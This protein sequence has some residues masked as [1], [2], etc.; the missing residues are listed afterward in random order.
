M[1]LVNPQIAM[2]YRPTVEY[3]PR[4]AL[5]D[6]AQVMSLQQAQMQM[7][8]LRQTDE[9]IERIRQ[10]SMK[11]GGPSDTM[12][13]AKAFLS[14]PVAEHQT[15][16]FKIFQQQRDKA[17]FD[18]VLGR[19]Y[20][21]LLTS[22]QTSPAAAAATTAAAPAAASEGDLVAAPMP[23]PKGVM[24][25]VAPGGAVGPETPL[26]YLKRQF[27]TP[28][29]PAT[30][31]GTNALPAA[32]GATAPAA[33]PVVNAMAAPGAAPAAG[34]TAEQ[35]RQEII[36][37]SGL[38]DP[39]AKALAEVLKGQLSEL[40]KTHT[41]GG[42]IVTGGGR[43]IYTAP[44][45]IGAIEAEIADLR[46]KGV[47]DNDPRIVA[48]LGKIGQLSGAGAP[49]DITR[50]MAE[51]DRLIAS[52]R[53]AADPDVR[54]LN[55]YIRK[56]TTHA[57]G[58][59]VTVTQEK[60]EAGEFGKLL[61][62]GYEDVLKAA[63]LA[64]TT[65]PSLD[66]QTRILDQGFTTGFGT[67]AKTAGASVLAALG[68][69]NAEKFATNS[70]TFLAATQQAVLQK[71]LEQKGT[72]TAADAER[73]TQT[74]AQRG[75]TVDANRFLIDVAREQLQRDIERKDFFL[76]WKE[77][78][79]SFSGAETAWS[80]TEGNKSLFDRPALKKYLTPSAAEVD[81]RTQRLEN[82]FNPQQQRRQ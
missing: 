28:G 57:P 51:R 17:D 73:I 77:R 11:E 58:T 47:K 13:I 23:S 33:A 22:R 9:A 59:T 48:R 61:V 45:Q 6:A 29:A 54:A 4:N 75:N 16:G 36:M 50:A 65:L 5:A 66:T 64:Q 63:N 2:S 15:M 76:D 21:D 26:S 41:V 80:R 12:E 19:L 78:T 14:S 49:L 30:A 81:K 55:D 7:D 10:V 3:Q 25:D 74:A 27:G 24:Q 38:S 39:R 44:S 42:R 68:V 56:Q 43:E 70:Q 62:R 82:I 40:T 1:A 79:G 31:T 46:Q 71:Q 8:K 37:L 20:P 69:K 34:K 53:T 52:G 67:D 32:V 18:R 60:S 72:Q 35:L